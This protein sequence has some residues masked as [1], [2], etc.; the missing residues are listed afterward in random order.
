M[1]EMKRCPQCLRTYWDET[2]AFCLEDGALLSAPYAPAQT[3]VLPSPP[4]EKRE[5]APTL[6]AVPATPRRKT[7]TEE[8]YFDF[9]NG[10]NQFCSST[11]TSLGI[12]K[13]S[14]QYW[15]TIATGRSNTPIS[16]TASMQKRRL[17]CEI[18]LMGAN[19]KRDFKL[20][21]MN[22]QAIEEKTGV[23]DWQELPERRD[24][25]IILYRYGVDI[26]DRANWN[27]AFAWL[28][29]KGELYHRTFSPF[30]K[31]LPR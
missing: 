20:L 2:L 26:S 10:F 19:A 23:L 29:S 6:P 21:E 5:S 18:Y 14:P 3:L 4:G 13:S 25:R 16:L 30:V 22:K 15:Y 11:G 17:G 31:A 8:L 7:R 9:W 1:C 12:H 28:K 24:C 27:D